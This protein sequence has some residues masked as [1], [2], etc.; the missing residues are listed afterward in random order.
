MSGRFR[1][2][3][4]V[5]LFLISGLGGRSSAEGTIFHRVP[6]EIRA[7][8]PLTLEVVVEAQGASVS[9][10]IVYYRVKGQSAY[11]EA[12]MSAGGADLYFGTIPAADIETA[13]LEYYLIALLDDNSIL[14]YPVDDPE[15]NPF[16]VRVLPIGEDQ[17]QA[18]DAQAPGSVETGDFLILSPDANAAY[19]PEDVVV[20]I[21]LFNLPEL[22]LASIKLI[23]NGRDITAESELNP[24]L[25]TYSPARLATGP[26]E[27]QVQGNSSAGRAYQ[28]VSLPFRVTRVASRTSARAFRYTGSLAPAFRSDDIDGETLQVGSIKATFRG[29]WE[30]LRLR[31]KLKL[32]TQEDPFRPPRNRFTAN[33]QT[34]LLTLGVGDVTPRFGRFGLAGKR[35]RGY[36]ANF[37]LG[38]INLR[39]AQGQLERVIQGRPGAAYNVTD[40]TVTTDE[41]ER[42][43]YTLG[44]DRGGYGFRRNISAFRPSLGSG[45]VFEWAISVIKAKDDV[46]SVNS[47]LLDGTIEIADSSIFTNLFFSEFKLDTSLAVDARVLT[48]EQLQAVLKANSNLHIDLS[49]SNWSGKSPQDNLV[50]GSNLSLA[51]NKRRFV[52]Q[53]GF[54]MSMLNRNIWDP[55]LSLKELDTFAPGDTLEDGFIGGEDGINLED[56]PI[57]PADLEPYFHINAN[58]VPLLPIATD[59][60]ALAQPLKLISKMPSLAYFATAKL[61]YLRNL[62]TLE[63][64]Q[65]GPE[66]NSLANPNLQR[67]VRIRTISDRARLFG[68]KLFLSAT[69]RTTDDDIVKLKDDKTT[70]L[71]DESEPITSTKTVNLSANINLGQGLPSI[72]LG[73]RS[74]VRE[75]GVEDLTITLDTLD[76]PIDTVD[77]RV[78]SLTSNTSL[79][80][81]YRLQLLSSTHDLNLTVSKTV[82]SDEIVGRLIGFAA[83]NVTSNI[84]GLSVNSRFSD[85]LETSA[86][87]SINNTET[88]EGKDIFA[89]MDDGDTIRTVEGDPVVAVTGLVVT[90]ILS[91]NLSARLLLM[92]GR[93]AV[94]GGLSVTNFNTKLSLSTLAPSS[95]LRLGI[96]GQVRAKLVENLSVVASIDLRQKSFE[97]PAIASSPSS[98]ISANLE[99]IF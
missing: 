46:G 82:I 93:V 7:Q 78:N 73:T 54:S 23:L 1:A 69:Y 88:G 15:V 63:F 99:Y 24:D 77:K 21:S 36:D 2:V 75:N 14:A 50:I 85:R 41:N 32:T 49:D 66:Y 65:V 89:F 8:E 61:N 44:L 59:S 67:N 79:G 86:V 28:S 34:P 20:A 16:F 22:E 64:Q 71:V 87:I 5:L 52:L 70:P 42:S 4:T 19:L 81:G 98:I 39:V 25:I 60:A 53:T 96:K 18:A 84:V 92:D 10:V 33:F 94:R 35:L 12:P 43:V 56:I 27:L 30:W 38:L 80:L 47:E 97:D 6:D 37:T 95:F 58:Q 40:Y 76:M 29:G 83:Q 62:I 11:L 91:L 26:Y 48:F 13:G 68:N 74:Y 72:T 57:D 55:V 9:S 45:R 51:L 3:G 31:G 90:D 17:L